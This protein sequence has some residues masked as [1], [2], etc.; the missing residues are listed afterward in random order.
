MEVGSLI[1]C[2]IVVAVVVWVARRNIK[3]DSRPESIVWVLVKLYL[4]LFFVSLPTSWTLLYFLDKINHT[5]ILVGS[6]YIIGLL[7]LCALTIFFNINTS[8]RQNLFL[9]F[10]SFFTFPL[11]FSITVLL[12][13]REN[14][15]N[16]RSDFN[17][18]A[19]VIISFLVVAFLL[20]II[21]RKKIHE[22]GE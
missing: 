10:L 7:S 21:F 5:I 18:Y 8:V 20:F 22:R 1:I 9:S 13:L 6:F 11:A 3:T 15:P 17:V 19:P 4:K 12:D 2:I 16:N 14:W